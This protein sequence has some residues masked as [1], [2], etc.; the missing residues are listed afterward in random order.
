[1]DFWGTNSVHNNHITNKENNKDFNPEVQ[2][3]ILLYYDFF[4]L[5][6]IHS[7][8]LFLLIQS[9]TSSHLVY[10]KSKLNIQNLSH[11]KMVE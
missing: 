1:M 3:Q 6:A 4:P 8:Y 10:C 2:F 11:E 7:T 9:K 5:Y